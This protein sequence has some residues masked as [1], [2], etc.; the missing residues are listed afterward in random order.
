MHGGA[1]RGYSFPFVFS[2]AETRRMVGGGWVE[3]ASAVDAAPL[4]ACS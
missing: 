3:Q 2:S 4:G 1:M